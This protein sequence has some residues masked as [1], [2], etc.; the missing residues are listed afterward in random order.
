MSD[1]TGLYF[2]DYECYMTLINSI[3]TRV[4]IKL[5]SLCVCHILLCFKKLLY[6]VT[7]LDWSMSC[8][9]MSVK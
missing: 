2:S 8:V 7:Q 4:P 6:H 5:F 9:T 1:Q 3:V